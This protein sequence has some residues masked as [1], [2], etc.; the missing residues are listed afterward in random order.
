MVA[1]EIIS[2]A[3]LIVGIF[4]IAAFIVGFLVSQSHKQ[5]NRKDNN[6]A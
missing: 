4:F 2:L 5:S 1:M 3:T 6:D